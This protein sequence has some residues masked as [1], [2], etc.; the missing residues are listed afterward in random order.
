MPKKNNEITF[1]YKK[2]TITIIKSGKHKL[3]SVFGVTALLL[4][5]NAS[6]VSGT[7]CAVL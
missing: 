4:F 7:I 3:K 5:K 1:L 6:T 2:Y